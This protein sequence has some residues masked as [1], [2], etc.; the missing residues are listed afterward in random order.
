MIFSI[1]K[2]SEE[3][4]FILSALGECLQKC[5]S[6]I[7]EKITDSI[8]GMII[9]YPAPQSLLSAIP[10]SYYLSIIQKLLTMKYENK[11]SQLLDS[12]HL[13][14]DI[15]LNDILSVCNYC[16]NQSCSEH[17]WNHLMHGLFLSVSRMD[18]SLS[19]QTRVI[20][21]HIERLEDDWTNR[22]TLRFTTLLFASFASY[23]LLHS[24]CLILHSQGLYKVICWI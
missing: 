21:Q 14:H 7:Y 1:E 20:E 5:P 3:C 13:I 16:S 11:V 23:P 8:I 12:L 15:S 2:P 18:V 17:I 10:S 22:S 19:E 9:K 6:S 4:E 24:L